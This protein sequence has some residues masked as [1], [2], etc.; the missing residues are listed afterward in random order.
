L[1]FQ[2][3][4]EADIKRL[5]RKLLKHHPDLNPNDKEA[6]KKFKEITEVNEVLVIQYRKKSTMT[7][8]RTLVKNAVY[9]K[10]PAK[11]VSWKKIFQISSKHVWWQSSRS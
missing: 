2:N 11:P 9:E 4:T 6:E 5:C 7:M 10:P 3:A 8:E 1:A